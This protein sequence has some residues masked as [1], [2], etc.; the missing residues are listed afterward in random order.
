MESVDVRVL[1]AARDWHAA[2]H[3]LMLATVVKTWGS[4]PRPPGSMMALREDGRCIGSVSG[5]CIEDD[6]ILATLRSM[7]ARACRARHPGWCAMA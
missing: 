3:R 2:G 5:G 7:A 1:R 4:S 6:L